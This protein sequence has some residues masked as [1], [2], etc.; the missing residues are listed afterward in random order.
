MIYTFTNGLID[1]IT[2]KKLTRLLLTLTFLIGLSPAD[3]VTSPAYSQ[4]K[5]EEGVYN[6]ENGIKLQVDELPPVSS[7]FNS[8]DLLKVSIETN[9]GRLYFDK[10][11]PEY[12]KAV[13]R[14]KINDSISVVKKT[15]I[16]IRGNTRVQICDTP[17]FK[18]DFHKTDFK[19][20]WFNKLH[21]LKVVNTC[22]NGKA[23]QNYLLNEY[24]IYKMYNVLTDM[25]YRVR[26]L[27]LTLKDS[28]GME[29][30][31]VHFAFLIESDKMLKKRTDTK[32]LESEDIK[33]AELMQIFYMNPGETSLFNINILAL[34][35]CMIGNTD[36]G[37]NSFHNVKI[38]MKN[39]TY[40][41]VPYDFDYAGMINAKYAVPPKSLPINTV[42]ERYYLGPCCK[43]NEF[44]GAL[45]VFKSSKEKMYRVVNTFP[46]LRPKEKENII[47]YFDSFFDIV[48]NP[49]ALKAMATTNCPY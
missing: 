40:S 47:N 4:S 5:V 2:L 42:R 27:E 3:F 10:E 23:Y 15:R 28:K 7:L 24:L 45:E 19:W 1:K 39:E 9:I 49:Q 29:P 37:S 48:D 22:G 38:F 14:M 17:P 44:D 25:S 21:A 20:K 6:S 34:F 16:K 8:T 26:L 33:M 43:N 11:N 32:E 36:W 13:F 18:I 46:Y 12:Q 35:Q 30:D 41:P 31:E